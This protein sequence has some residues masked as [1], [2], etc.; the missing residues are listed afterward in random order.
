MAKPLL[1]VDGDCGF[2][3]STGRAL[4][5]HLHLR[6]TVMAW[7]SADLDAVALTRDEVSSALWFV[8]G[9]QRCSGSQAVAA[10]LGTGPRPVQWLGAVLRARG[11]RSLAQATYRVVARHRGR[12]PGPWQHTCAPV[13]R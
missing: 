6:A 9:E 2:C 4:D 7:Q 8:D 3:T 1:L 11:I 10:W 5:R 13:T 12:I